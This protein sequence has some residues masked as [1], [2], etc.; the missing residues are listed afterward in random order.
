MKDYCDICDKYTEFKKGKMHYEH[1]IGSVVV[2]GDVYGYVCSECNEGFVIKD[3]TEFDKK[4]VKEYR[5]Y[6]NGMLSG[7]EIRRVRESLKKSVREFV[8]MLQ[9]NGTGYSI[10]EYKDIEADLLVHS[11]EMERYVRK[12]GGL[13]EWKGYNKLV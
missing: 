3:S 11:G 9:Q 2:E 12:I 13:P 6:H 4:Y 8:Q 5:A 1:T 10:D 7:E